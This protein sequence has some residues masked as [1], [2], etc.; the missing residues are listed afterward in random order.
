MNGFEARPVTP[1]DLGVVRRVIPHQLPL[2]MAMALARGLPGME[3]ILLSSVPLADLGA[4]TVVLRDGAGGFIGQFR[5]RAGRTVAQLTFLAPEP[6]VEDLHHWMRLLEALVCEAGKRGAHLLSAE[7]AEEHPAFVAFRQTGFVV[8][9]RQ[10]ILRREP[11]PANDDPGLLRP[12]TERDAIKI[13]TL[14]GNT[15]PRLLQQAEPLPEAESSGLVYETD[16]QIAAYLVVSE[17]KSGVVIK[18]F[19][20]PEAYD[21]ASAIILSA[22]AHLPRA[23]QV[24]VFVYAR[25]YQDWL[26]GALDQVEF[27]PCTEQA[28]M[29]KYTL[30]R[31]GRVEPALITGLEPNRQRQVVADGPVPLRKFTWKNRSRSLF[32]RWSLSRHNDHNR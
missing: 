4:P 28:L 7:V 16:G 24:P 17:G 18:P 27:E 5:Q 10:T 19:F 9:S 1:L 3:G 31:Q 26:R 23:E 15:V 2:D 30:V 20:H 22:L 25:A 32:G 21:Q 29:V 14:H 13:A 8:Y 6:Q 11:G 12:E